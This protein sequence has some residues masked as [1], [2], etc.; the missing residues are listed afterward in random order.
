MPRPKAIEP[1]DHQL[2]LRLTAQQLELLES[3]AHLERSTP[4]AYAHQLLVEHLAAMTANPRVQADLA[5]RAGYAAETA[6][7]TSLRRHR[8]ETATSNESGDGRTPRTQ[9]SG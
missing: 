2:L 4:N 1:R 8:S 7:T 6:T 9:P 5:N 3:V